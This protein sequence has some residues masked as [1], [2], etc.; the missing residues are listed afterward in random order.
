L[1]VTVYFIFRNKL[2]CRKCACR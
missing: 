2:S 1:G